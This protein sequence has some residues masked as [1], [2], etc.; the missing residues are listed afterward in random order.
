MTI[1][2]EIHVELKTKSKMFCG[3][4]NMET[5]MPKTDL[6]CKSVRPT[7]P[8]DW[9]RPN[10]NICPICMGHPGTLPVINKEAVKKILLV[11]TAVSGAI[12]DFTEFDRKNY[13]YPDI[14]KGYQISQYKFPLIS[15]GKLNGI[16]LTRIHLE[17]DTARSSHEGGDYSLVDF[18]RA[19][20]PLMELVTEP[21][22]H[23]KAEAVNFAKELQLLLQYLDV[24]LANMEKGEMRVEVNISV[25]PI[26]E[27]LTSAEESRLDADLTQKDTNDGF[28]YKDLTYKIRGI[29]FEVKKKLGLG[30]KEQIYHNALEI[31]FKKAEVK[32]ESKKN[33]SIIYEDKN[34]GTYQP[35]FIIEDQ[36]II[37]LKALPEVARP[38]VE[39]LWTYLK[40]CTYKLALL[41]NFGSRELEIKR[42]IYDKA[43]QIFLPN[44]ASILRQ[45][46]V[47]T[48]TKVEIK[49]INSFRAVGKA[50]DFE[51]ERQTS[52][53]E[54]GEKVVQE[55]RGWDENEEITF[56]QRL[57]ES[58]HD[59]RYFPEP[60]LPKLY[61]S[62]IDEFKIE[63][64][65]KEL[66]E[67]PWQKRERFVAF[68]L[69]SDDVESYIT[70]KTLSQFFEKVAQNLGME[71]KEE[72]KLA[73][74]YV[75]S[76]LLGLSKTIG[77]EFSSGKV[78]VENFSSL[79]TMIKLNK[80]SS[81]GGKD[82][83][84]IMFDNDSDPEEIAKKEGLL[85]KS[86]KSELLGIVKEIVAKNSDAVNDYKSGKDSIL[87][88]FV[89]LAM[90]ASKGQANPEI[91]K[92]LFIDILK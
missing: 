80:V 61:I 76:D 83:L 7:N 36:I 92:E 49:N 81:R 60:D 67:L 65:K 21:V 72:I 22:M 90:K 50:I 71:K 59:Y 53:I 40:G 9:S 4:A 57:K 69:K 39:Q 10:V 38:Q 46:A 68:G 6:L 14:P 2:L 48:G 31:E 42:V 84:K 63:N 89:G 18:N 44:S 55:T 87:Q 54:K 34:I 25:A 52:L 30:H 47:P 41:V 3:C 79:I 23:S 77:E 43:R 5:K 91:L 58:A 24:S 51:F 85:Q 82:I 28:L 86:D 8:K 88:F 33:I 37:E 56:S 16:D 12:A 20:V 1:G 75:L 13:F 78:S 45:S 62:E 73:S 17:E 15:G 35:D 66:P 27:I 29:L 64:L 26:T 11:G 70:N 32:F 19:G 74:N